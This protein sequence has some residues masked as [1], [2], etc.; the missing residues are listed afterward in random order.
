MAVGDVAQNFWQYYD[1]NFPVNVMVVGMTNCNKGY[2]VERPVSHIMAIE[3][4][5]QGTGTFV[6]NGQTYYTG[7]NSAVL[8]TKGSNHLYFTDKNDLQSKKWVVFDGDVME[9][10][11][12]KYLPKNTYYFENCNLSFYFSEIGK[13]ISAYEKDYIQMVD[14]V[15][16]IIFRMIIEMKNSAQK[17]G[18]RL[19]QKIRHTLDMQ[20]EGKLDLNSVAT[21]LNY[22]KNHIIRTFR[23][24]YGLTPY[25]YF[26]ERKL[27]VAKMYLTNT[28]FSLKEIAQMLSYTDTQYF[29][30]VFKKEVGQTPS[31]FRKLSIYVDCD[32][33]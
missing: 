23:Q 22:S 20:I 30:K 28:A 15:S 26:E 11:I 31:E 18:V 25:K 16:S 27:H 13:A 7:S 5:E 8:L 4:N 10:L 14:A 29:S 6:I 2:R 33:L 12:E 9:F 3:Y 1:D 19:P 17:F 32:K 21:E 24:E